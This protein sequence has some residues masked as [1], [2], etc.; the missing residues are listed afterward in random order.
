MKLKGCWGDP[1]TRVG[2]MPQQSAGSRWPPGLAGGAAGRQE[3]AASPDGQAASGPYI[4]EPLMLPRSELLPG[5][6]WERLPPGQTGSLS[7]NQY[8]L[9]K[10]PGDIKALN[11]NISKECSHLARSST[12][13]G[14]VL[15][16]TP[17]LPHLILLLLRTGFSSPHHVASTANRLTR[18]PGEQAKFRRLTVPSESR[19]AWPPLRWAL[20]THPPSLW[21]LWALHMVATKKTYQGEQ[22]WM[23]TSPCINRNRGA[24]R[25][26]VVWMWPSYQTRPE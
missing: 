19:A 20:G 16:R 7:S 12:E 22:V 9:L 18:D 15:C 17:A 8:V 14:P 6:R 26:Y 13:W 3:V 21:Y 2:E 11:L 25:A 23:V 10:G 24:F 5:P 1:L 4:L